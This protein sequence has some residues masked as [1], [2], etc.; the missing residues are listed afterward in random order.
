VRDV[1]ASSTKFRTIWPDSLF[2]VTS[3]PRK[4]GDTR[5]ACPRFAE[6]EIALDILYYLCSV[7]LAAMTRLNPVTKDEQ[8]DQKARF[9]VK[10]VKSQSVER[11]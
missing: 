7:K 4:A 10:S 3:A 1:P 8:N 5:V 6:S 9:R 2:C 11:R